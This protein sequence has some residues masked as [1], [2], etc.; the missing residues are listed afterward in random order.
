MSNSQLLTDYSRLQAELLSLRAQFEAN[1]RALPKKEDFPDDSAFLK[2][3]RAR[4]ER[5]Q[6]I[7]QAEAETA[8]KVELLKQELIS[9]AL[10]LL[11]L[12]DLPSAEIHQQLNCAGDASSGLKRFVA[13]NLNNPSF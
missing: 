5:S 6:T 3:L 10:S 12:A 8:N 7:S 9:L 13:Q 11:K 1:Y 4:T 2:A